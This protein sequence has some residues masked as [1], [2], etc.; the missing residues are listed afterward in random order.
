MLQLRNLILIII[1]SFLQGIRIL[2]EDQIVSVIKLLP[3]KE[4]VTMN[5]VF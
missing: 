1:A 4:I 5:L 2:L 3:Y